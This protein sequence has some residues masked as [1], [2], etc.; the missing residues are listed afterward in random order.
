MP[1]DSA[2]MKVEK[3]GQ[4]SLRVRAPWVSHQ[5]RLSQVGSTVVLAVRQ[6]S[7]SS[8]TSE[9]AWPNALAQLPTVPL[10]R[11][12]W[13]RGRKTARWCR[14]DRTWCCRGTLAATSG[15]WMAWGHGYITS[16]G[17]GTVEVGETAETGGPPEDDEE[18]VVLTTL[19]VL[20]ISCD[21][22]VEV[23]LLCGVAVAREKAKGGDPVDDM[24]PP[25]AG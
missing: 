16:S 15:S 7:D 17:L 18:A 6:W 1:W 11:L 22:R 25:R 13:P 19:P 10:E 9:P 2:E 4:S 24:L 21:S 23:L 20:R 12:S 8:K 14:G 3:I 5:A